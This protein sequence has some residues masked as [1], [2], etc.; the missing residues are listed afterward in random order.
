[1]GDVEESIHI[2]IYSKYNI[3]SFISH[4]KNIDNLVKDILSL[5]QQCFEYMVIEKY[6]NPLKK[7]EI[8]SDDFRYESNIRNIA[9]CFF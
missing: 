7:F 3:K 9:K 4:A 6:V 5:S 8:Y 2:I 1:M